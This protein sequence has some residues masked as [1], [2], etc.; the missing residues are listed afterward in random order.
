MTEQAVVLLSGGLDSATA[1]YVAVKEYGLKCHCVTFYYGQKNQREMDAAREIA[2]AGF[3]TSLEHI[4]IKLS[5][6]ADL[7]S[8]A[9]TNWEIPVPSVVKVLGHPQPPTYVPFRN[10]L[11]LTIGAQIAEDIGAEKV[12]YGA[13]QTDMHGYFDAT[14]EFVGRFNSVLRLNRLHKIQVYAP[15]INMTKAEIVQKGSRLGV[16]FHLTYSCYEGK[17]FHCGRCATCAERMKAFQ[18]AGV[19]DPT[20][21]L[22]GV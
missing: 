7:K 15:L 17:E 14:F 20:R 21:Y 13:H 18:D 1:L 4:H 8:S 11:F 22:A 3:S 5:Y 19:E 9:L 6:M 12:F 16:P 10:M 2:T